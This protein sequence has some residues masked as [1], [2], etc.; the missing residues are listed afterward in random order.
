[1]KTPLSIRLP[2][3]MR[4]W[5]E[6]EAFLTDRSLNATI[7]ALLTPLFENDSLDNFTIRRMGARFVVRSEYSNRNFGPFG[8]KEHALNHA[9]A[10]L[11]IN[12]FDVSNV[13]D[14]TD[15]PNLVRREHTAEGPRLVVA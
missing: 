6:T 14:E 7:V 11:E 1:M 2:Q 5:L 9:K 12:G 8:L 3:D 10:A 15:K 4:D 13:I